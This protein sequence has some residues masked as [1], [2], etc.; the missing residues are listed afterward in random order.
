MLSNL[1]EFLRLWLTMTLLILAPAV[2]PAIGLSAM[3]GE[4]SAVGGAAAE[5]VP[6]GSEVKPGPV[7]DASFDFLDHELAHAG[8]YAVR[9]L[10]G[11]PNEA[12]IDFLDHEL[13]YAGGYGLSPIP[14]V[15]S[16]AEFD[17]VDHELAHAGGYGLIEIAG[18]EPGP[19]FDFLDHELAYA[20]DYGLCA[21]DLALR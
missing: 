14:G 1:M 4:S 10:P 16:G 18:I 20:G 9:P 19:V 6:V 5:C 8:G 17:F 3:P 15:V 21:V 7:R 2:R 13:A 11:I 12:A